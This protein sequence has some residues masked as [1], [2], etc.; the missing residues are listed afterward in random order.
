MV[1]KK[2]SFLISNLQL[3]LLKKLTILEPTLLEN[4]RKAKKAGNKYLITFF[5]DD[6]FEIM[7]A[8]AYGVNMLSSRAQKYQ[9][10]KLFRRMEVYHLLTKAWGTFRKPE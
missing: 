9:C 4:I 3:E 10:K 8:V 6:L 2:I 7:G 1:I 5:D